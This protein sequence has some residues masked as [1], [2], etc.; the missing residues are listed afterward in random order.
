MSLPDFAE[1][2]A[3]IDKQELGV[4]LNAL[5]MPRIIQF[6]PN[7]KDAVEKATTLLYQHTII[8]AARISMLNL[9]KYHE[10][11]QTQI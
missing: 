2:A 3:S 9:R 10:W 6:D 11:L 1:F 7:D 8:M 5:D 4:E